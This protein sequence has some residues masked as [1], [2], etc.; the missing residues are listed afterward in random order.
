MQVLPS[1]LMKQT[2]KVLENQE[3][4]NFKFCLGEGLRSKEMGEC[5]GE[6]TYYYCKCKRCSVGFRWQSKFFILRENWRV[7]EYSNLG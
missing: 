4:W 5:M 7:G 1:Q 3:Q 6:Y 2:L